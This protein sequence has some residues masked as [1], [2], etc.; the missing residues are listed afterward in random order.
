MKELE[1]AVEALTKLRVQA[2]KFNQEGLERSL[3]DIEQ[4]IFKAQDSLQSKGKTKPTKAEIDKAVD[5]YGFR[6]PYDG[7]DK[8]YDEEAM[9]HFLA[10]VKFM[11][12]Y[13]QSHANQDGWVSVED[14]LPDLIKGQDYSAPVFALCEGETLVM[15]SFFI[16]EG[17]GY[18]A[19]ANCYGDIDGDGEYD[20]QYD[21]TYWHPLTIPKPPQ[22]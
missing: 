9:K 21:V 15:R 2:L 20:D 8:F 14:D 11:E 4:L 5:D 19:W 22:P 12:E 10:G 1:Q 7:S 13:A 18:R 17:D 6:V 3:Y 16:R